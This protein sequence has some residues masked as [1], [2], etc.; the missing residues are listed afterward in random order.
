MTY[1]MMKGWLQCV[2][3]QGLCYQNKLLSLYFKDNYNT[4][5]AINARLLANRDM[6]K[7]FETLGLLTTPVYVFALLTHVTASLLSTGLFITRY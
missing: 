1:L 3:P 6:V 4:T 2:Y 7:H 5:S